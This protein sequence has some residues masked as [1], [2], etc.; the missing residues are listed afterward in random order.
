[1]IALKERFD[2]PEIM[3][4]GRCSERELSGAL[5]FLRL[6]NRRFGGNAVILRHLDRWSR[7]WPKDREVTILDVGCG[8]A[9][10][11]RAVALHFRSRGIK[12]RI[13]GLEMEPR[14]A[15][16][17]RGHVKDCPEVSVETRSALDLDADETYD[18]VTASLFFHHMPQTELPR[19]IA[20]FDRIARRGIVISD[21]RRSPASYLGVSILSVLAGNS[22]V[23]HDGPLSV[24]RAFTAEELE[25]LARKFGLSYLRARNERFFRISLAG[26]KG[27]A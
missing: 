10:I 17:A 13:T 5:S 2:A 27:D 1:M 20:A 22:V 4:G 14:T 8:L 16:L 3:D 15:S 11:P 7:D 26:E 25:G 24:R 21:L 9:D 6:T 23:R 19:L 12:V 18:Y